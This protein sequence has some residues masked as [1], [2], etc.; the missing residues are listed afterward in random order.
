MAH[1]IVSTKN[2]RKVVDESSYIYDFHSSNKAFGGWSGAHLNIWKSIKTLKEEESF[3]Q[4]KMTQIVREDSP[5]S[6]RR[7]QKITERLKSLATEYESTRKTEF[8][9]SVSYNLHEF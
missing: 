6:C 7:Y 5:N 9:K 8:L 4:G 3:I 1:F 2:K